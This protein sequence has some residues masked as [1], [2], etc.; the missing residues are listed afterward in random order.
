MNNY[1]IRENCIFCDNILEKTFLNEDK[2]IPIT[3]NFTNNNN[4]NN[5]FIPYNILICNVCKCYQNKYLGKV[6]LVYSENHNNII[7]SKTWIN[8]YHSFFNFIL[9]NCKL[10]KNYKILEIGAGNNYIANLFLNH[11]YNNYTILEPVI[12]NK[13]ENIKYIT[14]WLE[15][16]KND[17]YDL[18]LLSHV[19]EH[20]YK[21]EDLFKNK[22]KYI[23][24]SIPNVSKHLDDIILNILNIEHTFY[25]E[26]EHIIHLFNKNGYKKISCD[27]FIDHSIF[28]LFEF[29]NENNINKTNIDKTNYID[30]ANNK[31]IDERFLLFFNKIYNVIDN[32]N[33]LFL[34]NKDIKYALFPGNLY[35]QYLIMFGLKTDNV[36]YVYDNN[37]NKKDKYLYG[38]NLICKDL[39]FF[40]NKDYCIILLGFLY[41]KEVKVLLNIHNI[42]FYEY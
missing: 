4:N 34:L 25:F 30:L 16:I 35:I 5:I 38:T 37:E 13:I 26:E 27:Y 42:K 2:K 7:I 28:M 32:V 19:F 33:N 15:S 36:N 17:D 31:N 39:E 18:I 1:L 29:C 41:N 3:T 8:Q 14:G 10:E 40:K 20:L 22:S 9:S 11:N 21:P 12:T 6:D 23:V 24:I